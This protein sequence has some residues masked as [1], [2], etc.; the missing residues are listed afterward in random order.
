MLVHLSSLL[1]QGINKTDVVTLITTFGSLKNIIN[2]DLE[3]LASCPGMTIMEKL[4]F[5]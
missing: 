4:I 2:A 1:F 5:N 3:Q